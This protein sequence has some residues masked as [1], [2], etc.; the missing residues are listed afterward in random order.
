MEELLRSNNHGTEKV[1]TLI[2]IRAA[3]HQL[4]AL[5]LEP[6]VHITWQIFHWQLK[7]PKQKLPSLSQSV[8]RPATY[9]T[10]GGPKNLSQIEN[11]DFDVDWWWPTSL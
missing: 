1:T 2:T 6:N 3:R 10:I 9:P 4:Y 7:R 11:P 5:G 8:D